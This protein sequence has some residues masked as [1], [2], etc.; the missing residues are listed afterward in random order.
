MQVRF[1]CDRFLVLAALAVKLCIVLPTDDVFL[2]EIHL[3]LLSK[4]GK[5]AENWR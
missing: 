3:V 5:V 4:R 1:Q 2:E